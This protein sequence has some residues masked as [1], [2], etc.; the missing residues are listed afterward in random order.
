VRT[1]G[2]TERV[3]T[4]SFRISERAL[5]A[6]EDE[7]RRQNVSVSTISNQLLL[8]FAE[9]DRFFR[10][11]GLVKISSA[12]FQRVL[13]AGSD[14]EVAEAGRATGSDTPRSIILAKYG[15]LSLETAIVYLQLQSEF[16]GL[17]QYDEVQL[18]WGAKRVITLLHRLGPKGSIFLANYVEAIFDQAGYSSKI[19]LSDHSIAIETPLKKD[20]GGTL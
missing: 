4:R 10:R 20:R 14:S 3:I 18:A 17:F 8:S 13:E 7:S 5:Q 16:S 1:R 19:S 6:I 9:F 12:T 11:L 2:K 15:T